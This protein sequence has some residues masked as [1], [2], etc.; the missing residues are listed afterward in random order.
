MRV[1]VYKTPLRDTSYLKQCLTDT[2]SKHIIKRY[3]MKL[4]VIGENSYVD[5]LRQKDI[6]LNVC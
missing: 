2:M 4:L 5:V 1:L 3:P 6:A